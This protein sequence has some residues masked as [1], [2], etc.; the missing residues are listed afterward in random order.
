M[1][2][3]KSHEISI[4]TILSLNAFKCAVRKAFVNCIVVFFCSLLSFNS[5]AQGSAKYWISF[6]DKKSTPYS[7]NNPQAFLSNRSIERRKKAKI[8]VNFQD[9]PVSPAYCKQIESFGLKLLHTSRWFN[10]GLFEVSD[11]SQISNIKKLSFVSNI[12]KRS[13]AVVSSKSLI[14][15]EVAEVRKA[16]VDSNELSFYERGY[17]PLAMIKAFGLHEKGFRGK[18]IMVAIIDAGFSSSDTLAVFDSLRANNQILGYRDFV[19][20]G[21]TNLNKSTHGSIVLGTLAANVPNYYVGGAPDA[22]YWLLRSEDA[23]TEYPSEEDNW[24]AAIEFAD[25]AGVDIVNTSLGYFDFDNSKYNHTYK[26][27]DGKTLRISIAAKLAAQ[28]GILLAISAGN[29]GRT[30]NPY[31]GAPADADEV[32]TVGAVNKNGIRS[33]FSSVG[34]TFDGRIKPSIVAQGEEIASFSSFGWMQAASGTSFSSPIAA[35]AATCL[36]QAFPNCSVSE[37]IDAICKTASK[38]SKPDSLTGYGIPD[39]DAAYNYLLQTTLAKTTALR[40]YPT[41][42]SNFLKIEVPTENVQNA[43]IECYSMDGRKIFETTRASNSQIFLTSEIQSLPNG[44]FIINCYTDKYNLVV[45][46]IKQKIQ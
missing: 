12:E 25:S 11:E 18:G 42:V 16:L 3:R 43:K 4:S 37:I 1:N 24:V 41:I 13:D 38:A 46:V 39:F 30:A 33:A 34:P 26:D 20:P 17:P 36:L 44:V 19:E 10:G 28:R 2:N 29:S 9:L 21:N 32:L 22:T 14:I 31:I 7:L 27:L 6:K 5:N 23:E 35:S 45:K 15:K 40:I 8:F